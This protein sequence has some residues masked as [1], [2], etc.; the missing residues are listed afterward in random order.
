MSVAPTTST[1]QVR[2][3]GADATRA[4]IL[5]VATE[6]FVSNGLRGTSADRIIE[7]VGITKVTFYRH[8]RT[9][10]DLIVAY[11]GAMA[12]REKA[13]IEQVT[14]NKHGIDALRAIASLIGTVSCMPGFRGCP[15][16]NAAAET[17]D[18]D[19]PVRT[20]VENHRQWMREMFASIAAEAGARDVDGTAAQLMMLRDG[21]MV[22]GYLADPADIADEL[23]RAYEAVVAAH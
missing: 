18:T 5:E 13:G 12:A 16:I 10:T 22:N 17:P 1:S 23:A 20:V 19:D 7:Q 21:A 9:K 2:R 11:L 14:E 6:M 3:G 15:F 8:F 4:R